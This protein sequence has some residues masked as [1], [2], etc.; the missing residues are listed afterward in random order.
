MEG[1]NLRYVLKYCNKHGVPLRVNIK[2]KGYNGNSFVLVN[3]DRSFLLNGAGDFVVVEKEGEYDPEHDA[4]NVEGAT[5]PFTLKYYADRSDKSSIIRATGATLSFY[6]NNVFNIDDMLTSS[7]TDILIEFLYNNEIEWTGFVTPDFFYNEITDNPIVNLTATDRLGNLKDIDY[8]LE[9]TKEGE[10][11]VNLLTIVQTCLKKTGL[12]LNV[13]ILL[14]HICKEWDTGEIVQNALIKTFVQEL[15]FQEGENKVIDCYTVLQSILSQ[16][17]CYITQYKGE[18][19]VVNKTQKIKGVGNVIKVDTAGIVVAHEPFKK[20]DIV[21]SMVDTG[22]QRTIV[23]AGSKNTFLY[24]HGEEQQYPANGKLKRAMYDELTISNWVNNPGL[25]TS[26]LHVPDQYNSN[27]SVVKKTGPLFSGISVHNHII[28]TVSDDTTNIL[29]VPPVIPI[30]TVPIIRSRIFKPVTFDGNRISFTLE[31][32]AVGKPRTAALLGVFL[33]FR[34]DP[35]KPRRASLR[36]VLSA[37]GREYTGEYEFVFVNE[38]NNFFSVVPIIFDN[39]FNNENLAATKKIKINVS[40][41]NGQYQN[42]DLFKAVM[43]VHIYPNVAYRKKGL[44]QD[45]KEITNFVNEVLIDFGNDNQVPKGTVFQQFVTGDFTKVMER[46]TVLFGDY[47][48]T[49][50]NGYLYPGRKDS[51]SVQ[52]TAMGEF[53]KN[54]TTLFNQSELPL[55]AHSAIELSKLWGRAHNELNIAFETSAVSP[56]AD[57]KAACNSTGTLRYVRHRNYSLLE[58]EM[59]YLRCMFKGTVTE[60]LVVDTK[61]TGYIY[62]YFDDNDLK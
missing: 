19:W 13:N 54:W 43:Y 47:Q 21:F 51:F 49:G 59:D 35:T 7:E 53:T 31:A 22:G 40:A 12:D 15:R 38:Q 48:E 5:N 8:P 3:H 28:T 30:G 50:Q 10:D 62:S 57:I 45:L 24:K 2:W 4:S 27:G 9:L 44:N 11:K 25:D 18:W 32:S 39:E 60:D 1:Y 56:I 41:A 52:Q 55:L 16:F 33:E 26:D 34:D 14:G 6:E 46:N 29:P 42:Y 20:K 61:S 17:N 37:D 58:G 36:P 23:P